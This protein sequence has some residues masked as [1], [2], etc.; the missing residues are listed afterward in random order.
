[1]ADITSSAGNVKLTVKPWRMSDTEPPSWVTTLVQLSRDGELIVNTTLSL[2]KGDLDSTS[3][4][5]NEMVR[6]LAK[7]FVFESSD[8]DLVLEVRHF[9]PDSLLISTWL[10]E[11]YLLMR[12]YRFPVTY[13]ELQRFVID[14]ARDCRSVFDAARLP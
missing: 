2:T 4:G 1:M 13:D 9:Q 6:R 3:A 5:L 12:G 14:L 8:A 11:P 7:T 10:G